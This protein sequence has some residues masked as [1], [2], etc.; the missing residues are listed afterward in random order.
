MTPL[1]LIGDRLEEVG[2]SGPARLGMGGSGSILARP[3]MRGGGAKFGA[4]GSHAGV[5]DTKFPG[6]ASEI[7]SA[8]KTCSKC[9]VSK[10]RSLEFFPSDARK[11]D[12]L[13]AECRECFSAPRRE[14]YWRMREQ[15]LAQNA[16]WRAANPNYDPRA[17][18]P[19]I[20]EDRAAVIARD[21]ATER[22]NPARAAMERMRKRLQ[23][24]AKG[25]G[26]RT[27]EFLG[28][29]VDHFRQ[30]LEAQFLP[31]MSWDNRPDWHID[32]I[33][34]LSSFD[35]SDPEQFKAVSHYTNLQPLWAIDNLRKGASMP[36]GLAA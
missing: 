11:R 12:G 30:H 7:F 9:E 3:E 25:S 18:K 19:Y 24:L 34:P 33:R 4:R 29:S 22:A 13:R 6:Q 14:R 10:P 28:C 2:F 20:A 21:K 27:I 16:A 32:H 5:P 15:I 36:E 23:R 26:N 8:P 31:G 17:V 35:L 1:R